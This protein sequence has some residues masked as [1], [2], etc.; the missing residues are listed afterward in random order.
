M[1]ATSEK[2]AKNPH[3]IRLIAHL[4]LF[5]LDIVLAGF[6]FLIQKQQFI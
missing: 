6:S 4:V 2:N 5:L 3:N 1:L